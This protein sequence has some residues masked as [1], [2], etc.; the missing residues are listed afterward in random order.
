MFKLSKTRRLY[1][2]SELET[3]GT[4]RDISMIRRGYVNGT[5]ELNILISRA[6]TY[7]Q[8]EALY[9]D[10]SSTTEPA[11][12]LDGAISGTIG[13]AGTI[14]AGH[15]NTTETLGVVINGI[16][17]GEFVVAGGNMAGITGAENDT[18]VIGKDIQESYR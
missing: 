12:Y 14:S 4:I 13:A 10:V 8:H 5:D 3:D 18:Y 16:Y 17:K 1:A 6:D 15:Y 2:W 11:Y 9:P 7:N